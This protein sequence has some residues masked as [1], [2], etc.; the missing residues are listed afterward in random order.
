MVSGRSGPWS[1]SHSLSALCTALRPFL[2]ATSPLPRQR[3]VSCWR[4]AFAP[5]FFCATTAIAWW[6][7]RAGRRGNTKRRALR[8]P[9]RGHGRRYLRVSLP[10]PEYCSARWCGVGICALVFTAAFVAASGGS[11]SSTGL[12]REAGTAFDSSRR[13][14]GYLVA[15]RR[16]CVSE[17]IAGGR[18]FSEPPG[19][20][21]ICTL[22]LGG[23]GCI[24]NVGAMGTAAML[25]V[26]TSNA[27]M[28]GVGWCDTVRV[29]TSRVV[30]SARHVAG[31]RRCWSPATM[32][33]SNPGVVC[34]IKRTTVSAQWDYAVDSRPHIDLE[35]MVVGGTFGSMPVPAAW[36]AARTF[37]PSVTMQGDTGFCCVGLPAAKDTEA[38]VEHQHC[39][40]YHNPPGAPARRLHRR[41]ERHPVLLLVGS[42]ELVPQTGRGQQ[43]KG[44]H[45]RYDDNRDRD[46]DHVGPNEDDRTRWTRGPC[47][48]AN[49]ISPSS[50]PSS[51][52]PRH[53]SSL[54]QV[55]V[56][57]R[58]QQERRQQRRR[59]HGGA[60]NCARAHGG[61][62]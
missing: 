37:R 61:Q 14:I 1:S 9:H 52:P 44:D 46:C 2:V 25:R 56:R 54:P 5:L 7:T 47:L 45:I 49:R 16:G 40:S 13:P 51:P 32:R 10:H 41:G 57:R 4:S 24:L 20:G 59:A 55:D 31:A 12:D 48:P 27:T 62:Q 42:E 30:C 21:L 19:R 29:T 26:G 58:G 38:E 23:V 8:P 15:E 60:G 35:V 11:R 43:V 33:Y 36:Q 22:R 34:V 3:S 28:L 17:A 6:R 18:T 39:G 53:L 50:S